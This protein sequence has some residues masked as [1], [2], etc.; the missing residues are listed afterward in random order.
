M[1]QEVLQHVAVNLPIIGMMIFLFLFL[2]VVSWTL[3]NRNLKSFKEAS[4]LP[5]QKDK[6]QLH[7]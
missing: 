5:L 4:Y 7:E 6:G 1:K 3:L 2:A